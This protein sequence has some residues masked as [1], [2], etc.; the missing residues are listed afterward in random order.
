MINIPNM[1]TMFRLLL[2]PPMAIYLLQGNHAAA[3][4]L[5]AVAALTDFADGWIARRFDQA[6]TFGR[7]VDPVADKLLVGTATALLWWTGLLPTWF[8]AVVALR[9]TFILAAGLYARVSGRSDEIRPGLFGKA[10]AA[11]QMV[12]I[13]LILLPL[14]AAVK[15]PQVLSGLMIAATAFTLISAGRYALRFTPPPR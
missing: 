15:S 2:V 11:A 1:L 10:G 12:L 3:G 14:P 4:W 13:A 8:A 9:E 6:T 7:L 5:F